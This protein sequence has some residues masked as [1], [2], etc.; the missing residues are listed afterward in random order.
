MFIE[1][2]EDSIIPGELKAED[3][4]LILNAGREA[5]SLKVVNNGDRPIQVFSSVLRT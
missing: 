1:N 3:G 4:N 2:K 5:V